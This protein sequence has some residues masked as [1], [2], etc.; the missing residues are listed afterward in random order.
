MRTNAKW[1]GLGL[2]SAALLVSSIAATQVQVPAPEIGRYSVVI[3]GDRAVVLDTTDG[4]TWSHIYDAGDR[5]ISSGDFGMKKDD[6]AKKHKKPA[7][8]P[9]IAN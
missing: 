4:R 2:L 8:A 6:L 3:S 7:P 5:G 1:F 9:V